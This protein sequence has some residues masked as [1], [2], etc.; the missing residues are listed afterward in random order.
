MFAQAAVDLAVLVHGVREGVPALPLPGGNSVFRLR[1]AR[2]VFWDGVL[3]IPAT[4]AIAALCWL[5]L[6]MLG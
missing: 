1:V 5:L 4:V 2:R 6:P 3:T